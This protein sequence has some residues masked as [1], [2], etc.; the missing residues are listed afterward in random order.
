MG[1]RLYNPITGLFTSIDPVF[2]GNDTPYA[3]PNDPINKQDTTGEKWSRR[4]VWDTFTTGLAVAS[5][6]GCGVCAAASVAIAAGTMAY[7]GYKAVRS[8]GKNRK[9]ALK[10]VAWE[11]VGL[12]PG[13]G[14]ML[15]R[16][17][18]RYGQRVVQKSYG[19]AK[20]L[21]SKVKKQRKAGRKMVSRGRQTYARYSSRPYRA[22]ENGITGAGVGSYCYSYCRRQR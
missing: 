21:K 22:Y 9:A 2:G 1:A 17:L 18:S 10:A 11:A 8:K 3:Y 7:H 16:G 19:K 12:I 6:F 15:G 4:K 5:L 20:S 14:R 13:G